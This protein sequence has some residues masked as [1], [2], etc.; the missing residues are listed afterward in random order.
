MIHCK[1]QRNT[2]SGVAST[3]R[4]QRLHFFYLPQMRRVRDGTAVKVGA[5]GQRQVLD[6][7]GHHSA[8]A[9][10][11]DLTVTVPVLSAVFPAVFPTVFPTVFVPW[12]RR[13]REL[14][15]RV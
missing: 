13:V 14:S 10:A 2:H 15:M 4:P 3:P 12:H 8:V 7:R 1:L 9:T 5:G 6:R 11:V